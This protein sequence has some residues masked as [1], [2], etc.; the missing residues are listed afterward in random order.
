MVFIFNGKVLDAD[1]KSIED[2]IRC[3]GLAPTKAKCI[4]NTLSCLF[5]RKGK[6]C[7]EYLQDFSVDEVKAELSHFKGIGPKT[8]TSSNSLSLRLSQLTFTNQYNFTNLYFIGCLC[9]DVPTSAR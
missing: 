6:L 9:F 2:A 5:E 3:G 7:L 8:V 1:S 4:K